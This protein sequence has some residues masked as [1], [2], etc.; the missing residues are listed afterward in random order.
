MYTER[1]N[2]HRI[3]YF[4]ML[5][6]LLSLGLTGQHSWLAALRSLAQPA[7]AVT[8]TSQSL[9][10]D[11]G[12]PALLLLNADALVLTTENGATQMTARVRD[13]EG[14]PVA[15]AAVNFSSTQGSVA[16]ADAVT[17]AAG[18]AMTSFTAGG[19]QGQAVVTAAVNGLTRDAAIQIVKPNSD[20]TAHTLALDFGVTKLDPGQEAAITAV[21]RD[22]AGQPVAGELVSLF[23]SLGE[24]T[25]AS[26]MSDDNGRITAS[27]RAGNAPGQ[28]MITVL[29][30]YAS[31]SVEFQVGEQTAPQQPEHLI[32]LPAVSK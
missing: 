19:A 11:A 27:Y 30:G 1:H 25:P 4:I 21:L 26:A 29:A 22:A 14:K 31:Q 24:V 10:V 17:D 13:A 5:I 23:G 16:P 18:V 6:G 7:T 3:S 15:G 9:V 2:F 8:T 28:A 32:F 12:P 20:A